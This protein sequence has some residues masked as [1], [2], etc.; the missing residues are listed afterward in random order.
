MIKPSTA[1]FPSEFIRRFPSP[2]RVSISPTSTLIVEGNVEIRELHLDGAVEFLS[3]SNS[4]VVT[5]S[6]CVIHNSGHS[7][8]HIDDENVD[9]KISEVDRMRG[10]IIA[11]TDGLSISPSEHS[12]VSSWVFNGNT[13][14]PESALEEEPSD[15]ETSVCGTCFPKAFF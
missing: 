4:L 11:M 2:S 15:H 3:R 12:D 1:L 14:I 8:F 5:G 13:V 7:V 6:K 10:Y 9:R